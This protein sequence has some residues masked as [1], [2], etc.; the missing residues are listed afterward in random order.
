MYK[1]VYLRMYTIFCHKHKRFMFKLKYVLLC[2]K[3][4]IAYET[5]RVNIYFTKT[6][7]VYSY[8]LKKK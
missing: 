4:F 6:Q 3:K 5:T 1:P 7:F 2:V 8:F